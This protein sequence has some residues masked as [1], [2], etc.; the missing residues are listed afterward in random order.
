[1]LTNHGVLLFGSLSLFLFFLH[2]TLRVK[3]DSQALGRLPAYSVLVSPLHPLTGIFPRIPGI[4]FGVEWSWRNV[5]E[6]QP[7]P[8]GQ[9][10]CLAY[11]PS[12]LDIFAASKSDII[13]IRSLFPY[14]TP[15]IIA[16]ATAVKVGTEAGQEAV[17]SVLNLSV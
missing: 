12:C 1:M 4:S 5:Y 15:L 10:F 11:I 17:I 7:L 3:K 6:S 16:D 14:S 8:K 9:F 13:Q 2:R